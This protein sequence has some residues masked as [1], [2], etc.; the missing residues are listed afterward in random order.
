MA[1]VLSRL[2]PNLRGPDGHV[3]RLYAGTVNAMI[4]YGSPVW[5]DRAMAT[6]RI[7]NMMR[8]IQRRVAIRVV[9]EYRTV[10]H[11]AAAIMAGLPPIELLACMYAEVYTQTRGLRG[12]GIDRQS[13]GHPKAPGPTAPAREVATIPF[14]S[15]PKSLWAAR[16]WDHSALSARLGRIGLEQDV[17]QNY[18]GVHRTWEFR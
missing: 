7:K 13:Q 15:A 2:L 3:R 10:S 8:C 9:R 5:A 18:T 6:R 16:C 1:A 11:T 12:R 4:L 17:I 14:E